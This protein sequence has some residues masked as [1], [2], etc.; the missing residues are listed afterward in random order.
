MLVSRLPPPAIV[1][2]LVGAMSLVSDLWPELALPLP[3]HASWGAAAF[4]GLLSLMISVWA[5]WSF[6]RAKTTVDPAPS[7]ADPAISNTWHLPLQP[8]PY[9]S[10]PAAVR[11]GLE[12]AAGQCSGPLGSTAVLFYLDRLPIRHEEQHLQ[13]KFGSTYRNYQLPR[14]PLDLRTKPKGNEPPPQ[15][16]LEAVILQLGRCRVASPPLNP[17]DRRRFPPPFESSC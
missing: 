2:L 15:S 16:V 3:L 9:V 17:Y 7:R 4:C 8:Q 11:A 13:R 12:L 5:L 1:L 6:R 14:S 10:V